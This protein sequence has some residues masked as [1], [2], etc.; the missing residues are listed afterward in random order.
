MDERRRGAGLCKR[1]Q[2][3][4]DLYATMSVHT[5]ATIGY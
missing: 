1:L 5:R 2:H 3:E 4:A